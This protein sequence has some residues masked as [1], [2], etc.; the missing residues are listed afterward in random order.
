MTT[1]SLAD[2]TGRDHENRGC[3]YGDV[4]NA[5]TSTAFLVLDEE[6]NN[7]ANAQVRHFLGRYWLY[8]DD[9]A[10]YEVMHEDAAANLILADN[11]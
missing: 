11:K 5:C 10:G 1:I 9:D 7:V 8:V 6:G 3:K 4:W 2:L